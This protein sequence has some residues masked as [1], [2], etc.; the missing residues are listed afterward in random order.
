MVTL[1]PATRDDRQAIAT[2]H[3]ASIRRLGRTHYDEQ[4]VR[5]WAG[6]KRP[7]RYPV[8]E[9]DEYLVVAEFDDELAGYGHLRLEDGEV[10]AVYVSPDFA[11]RGVGRALLDHLESIARADGHVD[12]YLYASLNAVP[13]YEQAGWSVVDEETVE[14]SGDGVTAALPVR[15][16]E[17]DFETVE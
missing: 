1:R 14:T 11:R 2:M 7:E 6:N 9:E 15:V 12:C 8:G 13:F 5:A 4:Q 10:R 17:K 3:A 16:M